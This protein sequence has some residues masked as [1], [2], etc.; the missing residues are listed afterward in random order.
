M[1]S[2]KKNTSRP[3]RKPLTTEPKSKRTAQ[4]RAAQRAFR[5]RKE[6]KMKELE[7][8]VK[9]LESEK[10]QITNETELLRSQVQTLL[11][12]LSRHRQPGDPEI[13]TAIPKSSNDS[14]ESSK[15]SPFSTTSNSSTPVVSAALQTPLSSTSSSNNVALKGRTMSSTST[16]QFPSRWGYEST[17]GS[18]PS[19]G[20]SGAPIID[21][22]ELNQASFKG[23]FDE[24][25]SHFCAEMSQVCGT[26]DCPIPKGKQQ[27]RQQYTSSSALSGH[28]SSDISES[29]PSIPYFS[30][31]D[32]SNA[33]SES[34]FYNLIQSDTPAS[35]KP[36]DEM[37]FLMDSLGVDNNGGMLSSFTTPNPSAF[38]TDEF[39]VGGD[40]DAADDETL[41]GLVTETSRYDP[42]E[43]LLG[44]GLQVTTENLNLL[45]SNITQT[46]IFEVEEEKKEE[47][48]E[49]KKSERAEP[50]DVDEETVPNTSEHF[51]R[52]SQIWERITAHPR[53]REID[54]DGLCNELKQ[55]AKC[56]EYGVV[57]D[58]GDVGKLLTEALDKK[59]PSPKVE[60]NRFL[61]GLAC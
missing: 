5:E 12:E 21:R 39:F 35:A 52:C 44:D 54:I 8:K 48:E 45:N 4:N 58:G 47:E 51:L 18:T 53:F 37:N 10:L 60:E 9:M 20:S 13:P 31:K 1:P 40:Q 26:K 3:G 23:D 24:G 42:L 32:S 22:D 29:T 36:S 2:T 15:S 61:K 49:K 56:S 41:G 46:P 59:R 57:V 14:S 7:T 17:S 19:S 16:F 11:Q 33:T 6:R 50:S 27:L 38:N 43:D 25:V 55:K 34:P 30:P 28:N